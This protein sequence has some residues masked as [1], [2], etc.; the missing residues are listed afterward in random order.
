MYNMCVSIHVETK[1]K[2]IKGMSQEIEN[3]KSLL[4]S[5]KGVICIIHY[6]D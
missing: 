4:K 6:N 2:L 5:K 3:L 1:E